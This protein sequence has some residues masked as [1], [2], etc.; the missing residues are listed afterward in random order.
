VL[1]E[2]YVWINI[3]I[4]RIRE[5]LAIFINIEPLKKASRLQKIDMITELRNKNNNKKINK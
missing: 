3:N 4:K 2:T 5:R 1:N